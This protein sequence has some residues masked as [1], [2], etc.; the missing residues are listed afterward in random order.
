MAFNLNL[1]KRWQLWGDPTGLFL[2]VGTAGTKV[3]RNQRTTAIYQR[4]RTQLQQS[5]RYSRV[6]LAPDET[7]YLKFE[8]KCGIILY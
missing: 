4:A 8:G 5:L 1:M 6:D 2:A 7:C 3:L